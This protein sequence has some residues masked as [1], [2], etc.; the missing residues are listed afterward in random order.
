MI[1]YSKI[2]IEV[3]IVKNSY[4]DI[5]MVFLQTLILIENPHFLLLAGIYKKWRL[6][7]NEWQADFSLE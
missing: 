2:E 1:I 6:A 7:F 3:I 4:S 5:G